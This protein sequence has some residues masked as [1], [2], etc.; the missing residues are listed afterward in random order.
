MLGQEIAWFK[1]TYSKLHLLQVCRGNDVSE[2]ARR[3][4]RVAAMEFVYLNPH[5][6]LLKPL[7][8]AKRT[9][10]ANF[11][12]SGSVLPGAAIGNL[13]WP[14]PESSRPVEDDG[15]AKIAH[16]LH[17][18]HLHGE[19]HV[20]ALTLRNNRIGDEGA[21]QLAVVL[22]ENE[23][24]RVLDLRDNRISDGGCASLAY[25]LEVNSALHTLL[26][27]GN[28]INNTG[29]LIMQKSLNA[30][31]G[32]RILDLGM[33]RIDSVPVMAI[34]DEVSRRKGDATSAAA[35]KAAAMYRTR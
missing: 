17:T 28:H 7:F 10:C 21:T 18:L 5:D 26:L 24:L 29:F 34:R 15:A 19:D 16:A 35:I 27:S 9:G 20:K 4:A 11:S 14:A 23:T 12:R 8:H 25:A 13:D 30:N 22:R 3:L 33:N 2:A 6:R 1:N 32:I 31:K